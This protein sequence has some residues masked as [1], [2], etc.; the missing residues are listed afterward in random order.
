MEK[1]QLM[2]SQ[3][4]ENFWYITLENKSVE[5][6]NLPN[7]IYLETHNRFASALAWLEVSDYMGIPNR[8]DQ[9]LEPQD[10]PRSIAGE[11]ARNSTSWYK[12][13]AIA[14]LRSVWTCAP[15]T[16]RAWT[17]QRMAS[18]SVSMYGHTGSDSVFRMPLNLY[19]RRAEIGW[20]AKHQAEFETLRLMETQ[21]QVP[22]PRGIDVIRYRDS[23]F[24]LMTGVNGERVGPRPATLTDDQ[25]DLIVR[26][27]QQY[28]AEIR[29]IPRKISS[30]FQICNSLGGGILDWRI[31]NSQRE[32][33]KFQNEGEFHRYLDIAFTA[34]DKAILKKAHSIQHKIVFTHADINMRNVLVDENGRISEIVDWECAGW[35]PEYWEYTK[36]HFGARVTSR[37]IADV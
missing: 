22:A 37:W 31:G 16:L 24:L 25:V 13:V 2:P 26:D 33:L 11:S 8:I 28:T 10:T 27:L 3:Q 35:Y 4:L 7:T 23:S 15:L 12:S 36:M 6:V 34:E 9:K 1:R 29:S 17:Y 32:I 14:V 5:F 18:I 30:D 20:A 19:L 21:T